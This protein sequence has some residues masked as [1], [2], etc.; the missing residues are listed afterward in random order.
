M[1]RF[2]DLHPYFGIV[3][4][5]VIVTVTLWAIFIGFSRRKNL[6]TN[7]DEISN[8]DANLNA[9]LD[10]I[11]TKKTSHLVE[12][13]SLFLIFLAACALLLPWAVTLKIL[14]KFG[15]SIMMVFIFLVALAFIYARSRGSL[16]CKI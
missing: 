8:P 5:F 2:G 9:N 13:S 6:H 15:L 4:M 10:K 14:G 12:I 7:L 16:A 3:L 11:S 1:S